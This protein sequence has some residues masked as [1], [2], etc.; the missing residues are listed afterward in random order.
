MIPSS[1]LALLLA[2]PTVVS[3]LVLVTP[4]HLLALL[5]FDGCVLVVAI[6]DAL[7]ARRSFVLVERECPNVLAVD[8]PNNL[9]L[10][11]RSR[12]RRLLSVQITDDGFEGAKVVG[13]PTRVELVARGAARV[14]YQIV[15]TRRG[16][17]AL[18]DIF[19]RIPSPVGLFIWQHR[20]KCPKTVRVYPDFHQ[21]RTYQLLARQNRELALVRAVRRPGGESEFARL[22][23]YTPDDEYRSIDWKATARRQKL[24][25]REYQL[26][27]NQQVLF[28]LDGGRM[29]TG[30][31]QGLTYYDHALNASLMLAHV[32]S[33]TGDEVGLLSFAERIQ[34]FARPAGGRGAERRLILAGYDLRPELAESDYQGALSFVA[35]EQRKRALVVVFT[36]VF[37]G[38][39]ARALLAGTRALM[40]RHLPLI[41]LF[42]DLDLEEVLTGEGEGAEELYVK[43]AAAELFRFRQ[44]LVHE[45]RHA[46]ALVLQPRPRDLTST[47]INQYL[48]VK[49]RH[50]L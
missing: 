28:V 33:K 46:G 36:Q 16:Q 35:R 29:M 10:R 38:A 2:V 18:G 40:S 23:D 47:L 50:L 3:L 14:T 32:A 13:L 37:D 8:R 39:V 11:L 31:S 48:E 41:V 4:Q 49:A 9:H 19:L 24:V 27:S 26:E 12:A 43:G 5:L 42:R 1:R 6:L 25:A 44:G 34:A 21:V 45:L 22:R 20:V 7:L 30:E 17:A 15:P